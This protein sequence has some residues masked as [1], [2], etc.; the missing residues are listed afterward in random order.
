MSVLFIARSADLSKWAADVGLGKHV[1]KVGVAADKTAAKTAAE[2]GWAGEKDWRIVD[3][4]DAGDLD[5]AA[6]LTGIERKEKIASP[7]YYPR[8]KGATGV[9]RVNI[10]HVQNAM[11]VSQA[12]ESANQ[13]LTAPKPKP[14]DVAAYLIRLAKG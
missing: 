6:A 7:D 5:E 12:L 4:Q 3:A 9:V 11:L 13:P 8:L 14:K 1:F 10:A 2:Q